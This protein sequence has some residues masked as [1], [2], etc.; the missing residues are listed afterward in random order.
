MSN[1][2]QRDIH[3]SSHIRKRSLLYPML[4]LLILTVATTM[5]VGYF[6]N[7]PFL[8][9]SLH[10]KSNIE[11]EAQTL[12]VS[13]L[14]EHESSTLIQLA[15]VISRDGELQE[16]FTYYTKDFNRLMRKV[17]FLADSIQGVDFI[18]VI[19]A[20]GKTLYTTNVTESDA[21][22]PQDAIQTALKNRGHL[23]AAAINN[24]WSVMA[25]APIMVQRQTVGLLLLGFWIDTEL[26]KRLTPKKSLG[27]AFGRPDHTLAPSFDA[28]AWPKVTP[29]QIQSCILNKPPVTL[30][31]KESDQAVYFA[32]IQIVDSTFCL[33]L[34]LDL[35]SIKKT[36]HDHSIRLAWSSIIIIFMIFLLGFT[37]HHL[38][39]K[40]LHRLRNKAL[41]LVEVC[42]NE[43]LQ[44][45]EI[46]HIQAGNE[47]QILDQAFETA[48]TAIYSYIGELSHQKERFELMAIRD[49]LTGLGNR[50][51]FNQLLDQ[52][53]TI[54]ERYHRN[55]AVMYLD[56]DHFKPVNDTLG[57]DIGDLLL[58]EVAIRLKQSLRE[59]DVIF[60][61]GGDEF[62]ALLPECSGAETARILGERL[63]HDVAHPYLLNGHDCVIGVSVGVALFPDH[64]D[65]K[66]VLLK[67]ADMAL[68]AAKDAGR[69]VC[70]LYSDITKI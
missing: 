55:M 4:G 52:A 65:N 33:I 15:H 66:E 64:A 12:Q 1:K 60:R 54:C 23:I 29:E 48:S 25:I 37:V 59:S 67:H 69:G 9:Q 61:L 70:R 24:Q 46:M 10:N 17:L 57:H 47:I 5:G 11:N 51:L 16:A 44:I 53:I 50:R 56:L 42:S 18:G 36:L 68:Y 35:T 58:K 39:L 40:P 27:I 8:Y 20:N 28:N 26:A 45:P 49:P 31:Q 62:A 43:H 41:I 30:Y 63:I 7:Y 34:P 32:P 14:L 3:K 19:D 22:F 38:I 6:I 21:V 2:T 13:F